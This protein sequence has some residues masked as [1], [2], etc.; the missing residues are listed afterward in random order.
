MLK[1]LVVL[2]AL[3]ASPLAAQDKPVV[4]AV[5]YP[6]AWMAERLGGD[7]VEVL[8][9]VPADR[10]PS[11]W[12]PGL[13]DISAIQAADV[14]ALNG[15][16]FAG[17][18]TRTSLPRSRI[19]DTS[20]GFS[21][22]YISTDSITHS[23]G[24][25]GEHSHTGTASYTW[26]DFGQAARQAEALAGMMQRR[27]PGS[28][29]AVVS[30]LPGLVADLE[31]LDSHARDTLAPLQGTA[32]IATHPRYQYFARA[33]GLQIAALDWDAGAMPDADQWDALQALTDETGAQTLIWEA[34][35]PQEALAQ[36]EGMGLRSVVFAPLAVRPE[37]GEFQGV[38]RGQ[39][40]ALAQGE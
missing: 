6:L 12:R 2:V 30:A 40:D 21:D 16:G 10:D 26:L 1:R 7:A 29:D 15:A 23:H 14:I 31:A 38:M 37:T 34:A 5:N 18:T 20:A 19:V 25:D 3:A 8:F 9:P 11:F 17:W 35:P 36:A 32:M 24:A 33:Y 28:G 22:D 13:S 27:I 39:I 4:A